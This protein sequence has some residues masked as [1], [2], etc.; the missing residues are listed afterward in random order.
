M[1]NQAGIIIRNVKN[2]LFHSA[3]RLILNE[4]KGIECLLSKYATNETKYSVLRRVRAQRGCPR[5]NAFA[6]YLKL[7]TLT[8]EKKRRCPRGRIYNPYDDTLAMAFLAYSNLPTLLLTD[9]KI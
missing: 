9:F 7:V 5:R 3:K 6:D 4:V 8:H 2:E 1:G